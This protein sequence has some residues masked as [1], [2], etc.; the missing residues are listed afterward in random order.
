MNISNLIFAGNYGEACD[1][2]RVNNL[3][4]FYFV[5]GPETLQGVSVKPRMYCPL[6]GSFWVRKDAR[7]IKDVAYLAGIVLVRS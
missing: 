1:Y 7:H 3:K 4:R 5:S 2:A 6:V